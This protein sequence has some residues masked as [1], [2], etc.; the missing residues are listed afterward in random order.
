[1]KDQNI[2]HSKIPLKCSFPDIYSDL[3]VIASAAIQIWGKEVIDKHY[4][5]ELEQMIEE[6]RSRILNKVSHQ[7]RLYLTTEFF[8][9]CLVVSNPSERTISITK[10]NAGV[11]Q[12]AI[13]EDLIAAGPNCFMLWIFEKDRLNSRFAITPT[14]AAELLTAF[15]PENL[16]SLAHLRPHWYLP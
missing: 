11:L 14:I 10:S 16:I 6:Y 8:W 12:D 9:P 4:R 15:S 13:C 1:M 7:T 3:T 2:E 5:H